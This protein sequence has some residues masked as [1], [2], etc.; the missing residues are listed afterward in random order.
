MYKRWFTSSGWHGRVC[1]CH[2]WVTAHISNVAPPWLV[3]RQEGK[4]YKQTEVSIN[5]QYQIKKTKLLHKKYVYIRWI[6]IDWLFFGQFIAH[7]TFG[8]YFESPQQRLWAALQFCELLH[9]KVWKTKRKQLIVH[10]SHRDESLK[11]QQCGFPQS[12]W[13]CIFMLSLVPV[14]LFHSG[15]LSAKGQRPACEPVHR[16]FS[17]GLWIIHLNTIDRGIELRDWLISGLVKRNP[18]DHWNLSVT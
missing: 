12:V 3:H 9:L 18:N 17:D 7:D 13:K 15:L 16:A 2:I 4:M 6:L 14:D 11:S 1:G 10:K 5:N 8:P